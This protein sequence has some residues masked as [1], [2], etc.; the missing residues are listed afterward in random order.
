MA[1]ITAGTDI[2]KTHHHCVVLD[3]EGRKRL[4]RRVLNDEPELLTLLADVLALGEDVLWAVGVADGHGRPVDQ[5]AA[6][7]RPA[8]GLHTGPGGQPGLSR[9]PR[10]GQDRLGAKD[11][12]VI[13]DQARMRRD[14]TVLRPDDEHA[15]ELRVLT[16]RRADLT[17]DRT[18]RIN[19]LRGQRTGIFLPWSGRWTWAITVR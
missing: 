19:R 17:A 2:G 13:A 5:R 8:P 18:C 4:S 16:N 14:L 9:L 1:Q 10:H 7:P 3:A 6:Q 11:A 12:T 15:I